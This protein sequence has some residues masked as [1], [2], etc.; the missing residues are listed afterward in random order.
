MIKELAPLTELTVF[1]AA[2]ASYQ[3]DDFDIALYHLGNNADH[4]FVYEIALR[5][6]GVVVL[7][8][9]NL[10]H[11][12]ADLTIRRDDWDGYVETCAHDGG[13]AARARAEVARGL[14]VGPD[15]ENV[16]MLRR[17]AERSR[18]VVA[19]SRYVLD[20]A[21]QAGFTGPAA[22]IP[23][24]AWVDAPPYPDGHVNSRGAIRHRLG[25]DQTTPLIGAFGYLKPYK[26][27]A[28]S[29]RA[30][31]RLIR[32]A[33]Q[34]K[35][36]LGGEPHPDL[37]I[38]QLIRT[39]E[40]D[41]HVRLL[42]YTSEEDF[43]AYIGACDIIVNLR[44]P[45]VGETSGSLLRAFSAGLPALVSDVGA[46]AELPDGVCLKV[47]VDAGE[48]DL[49]YEYLDLLVSRPEVGREIGARARSWVEAD[50]GWRT[51]ARKF[52]E[53]LDAVVSGTDVAE[54]STSVPVAVFSPV[55]AVPKPENKRVEIDPEYLR[56]WAAEPTAR[57]YFEQHAARL[58]HTLEI[59]PP[60]DASQSILEMGAYL[61]VTPALHYKLGYGVVRGCYFGRSGRMDRRLAASSDGC[62]FECTVDHFDAE[63]DVY[64]YDDATFDTVLCGE[65]IEHL[66]SDPMFLMSE[67]NRILK[68]GGHLVLTTPNIIS[69]RAVSAILGSYHPGFFANYIRPQT[70]GQAEARHNREYAPGEIQH[71][72]TNS[73]FE[74]TRLETGPF[75]DEPHPEF[76]WVKVLLESLKLQT[77]WRGDGIYAVGRKIGPVRERFPGWLYL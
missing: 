37:P 56:S 69:Y 74:L 43:A 64:P 7:H 11:L 33:P 71:L 25:L 63:K 2:P 49:I 10:H 45:T 55:D 66:A 34:V 32:V 5:H 8:E 16:P 67:V 23:H 18:G 39:L 3:P 53:F 28:E 57:D 38:L 48:E 12:I 62:D 65:L 29:L 52:V 9:A 60:G 70:D 76:N 73:G 27:I 31:R 75:R 61:Q 30:L 20:A 6:P 26:R 58:Q 42:G 1:G 68:P 17:V 21:R 41:S 50:C 47:P 13:E 36:I 54:L 46:F 77:Y 51:V 59:T 24:G 40:L 22:V 4:G 35:M 72:L 15:Y 19:H 44:F 14:S